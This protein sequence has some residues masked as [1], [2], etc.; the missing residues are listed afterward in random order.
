MGS[1]IRSDR[2]VKRKGEMKEAEEG[3]KHDRGRG[4][5]KRRGEKSKVIYSGK[6]NKLI[7]SRVG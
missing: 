3:G 7:K 4:R 2:T 5:E 1:G 6:A